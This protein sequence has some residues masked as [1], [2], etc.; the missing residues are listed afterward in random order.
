MEYS[1]YNSSAFC[2][3]KEDQTTKCDW[4]QVA[5]NCEMPNPKRIENSHCCSPSSNYRNKPM[6]RYPD[7]EKDATNFWCFPETTRI[8]KLSTIV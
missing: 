6:P 8:Y 4:L 5:G 1:N 7:T 2:Y 3:G